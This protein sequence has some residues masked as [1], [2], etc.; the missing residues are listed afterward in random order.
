MVAKKDEFVVLKS[1]GVNWRKRR[2]NG[3]Y[4]DGKPE[5]TAIDRSIKS[6][7]SQLRRLTLASNKIVTG[8]ERELKRLKGIPLSEKNHPDEWDAVTNRT[9][10]LMTTLSNVQK[11]IT[12]PNPKSKSTN[13]P[14]EEQVQ[15]LAAIME[16]SNGNGVKAE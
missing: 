15:S 11:K 7:A 4:S 12:P 13:T 9:T 6:I 14:D 5:K 2:P 8:I 3:D 16:R 10:K 1:D